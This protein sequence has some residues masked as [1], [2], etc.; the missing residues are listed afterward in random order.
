MALLSGHGIRVEL[1]TGFEGRIFRRT[2]VGGSV[3]YPVAQFATFPLTGNVADFGGSVTVGMSA[4]DIF[5]VLFE[6][7][8]ESVGKALFNSEAIPSALTADQFFPYLLRRGV[9]GQSGTQRF[10]TES[11]RPFTFY[12]VLGSHALRSQLVPQV[13]SL[14]R[15]IAIEPGGAS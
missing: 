2:P 5:A 10:F 6:F 3:A 4:T 11:G 1:P 7:G 9:G 14:L 15:Q 8:P 12:A 13:N